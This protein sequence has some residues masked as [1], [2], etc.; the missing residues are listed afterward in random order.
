MPVISPLSEAERERYSRQLL[1]PEIGMAGQDRLR[2]ARVLVVGTGGL[3]SPLALYLAAA[4]VGTLGLVDF[5]CVET[6]NLQRQIIHGTGWVGR[7]K[8]DSA[9]ARL[10][11][12]NPF[13]AVEP[14]HCALDAANARQIVAG[15]DIVAGATDNYDVRYVTNDVCV[16]LGKPSV[17]GAVFQFEGQ[18]SVF[19]GTGPCYRCL[20]PERPPGN[21]APPSSR[22]GMLGVVPGVIGAL[23]ATE[24]LKCILRA[25]ETL[26]GKLLLYDALTMSFHV[27]AIERNPACP[28]C[29]ARPIVKTAAAR[30]GAS[31]A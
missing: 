7:P 20:Y 18:V 31:S 4:G 1:L 5:D 28:A 12:L 15:Y 26:N 24:V 6:S 21:F 11:D 3:G 27:L 16:A 17:Y 22:S 8:L 29:G 14:H 2:Q 9:A 10:A 30:I 19:A 23:Q 25:G 13:V